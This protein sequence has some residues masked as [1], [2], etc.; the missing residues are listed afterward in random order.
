MKR[1]TLV[2]LLAFVLL[3]VLVGAAHAA[4]TSGRISWSEASTATGAG[5]S[6]HYGYVTTTR[7]CAVCHAVHKATELGSE[8]LLPDSIAGSCDYC[9]VGGAGGYTQVY[10]GDPA[11]YQ[12][13]TLYNHSPAGGANAAC[14]DCHAV[15]AANTVGDG[16]NILRLSVTASY[17][18]TGASGSTPTSSTSYWD[19]CTGCHNYFYDE[20]NQSSHVMTD[21]AGDLSTYG[22]SQA[23][24][25]GQ[26][27]W[28][29]STSCM[30]CHDESVPNGFPHYVTTA[31][32]R[33]LTDGV[34]NAASTAVNN[35]GPC[36][37]CHNNGVGAGVGDTF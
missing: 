20:Y 8:V 2:V 36:L 32:P 1:I 10:G 33:F 31:A 11:K 34:A 35:D 13:D 23:G 9:H 16:Q 15:H 19:W 22:N 7:N 37:R 12:T 14:S 29:V 5:T 28:T 4:T 17:T 3:F 24:Y 18:V 25:S 27:A 21:S 30:N 6:P 26:V